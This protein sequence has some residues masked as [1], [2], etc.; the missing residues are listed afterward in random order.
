MAEESAVLNEPDSVYGMLNLI[1]KLE[2]TNGL[3]KEVCQ[4][5]A[6]KFNDYFTHEKNSLAAGLEKLL[7][8]LSELRK[9]VIKEDCHSNFGNYAQLN[10]NVKEECAEALA[11]NLHKLLATLYFW[12]F[13]LEYYNRYYEG[14]GKWYFYKC[15]DNTK[16]M[17][18]WLTDRTSFDNFPFKRG[19]PDETLM[20]T[21]VSTIR[22]KIDTLRKEN[23][24]VALTCTWC[25]M[26]ADPLVWSQLHTLPTL[27]L[28][29]I[30]CQAVMNDKFKDTHRLE[31][32][33]HE[34]LKTISKALSER[35]M[36][37]LKQTDSCVYT[38]FQNKEVHEMEKITLN[39]ER[40]HVYVLF[41][42]GIIERFIEAFTVMQKV[43][44]KWL[45]PSNTIYRESSF[46]FGFV[47]KGANWLM[48]LGWSLIAAQVK[49][50]AVGL[51]GNELKDKDHLTALKNFLKTIEV[52][53][54]ASTHEEDQ[55]SSAE[56]AS[57]GGPSEI[58][59]AQHTDSVPQT[60]EAQATGAVSTADV[61]RVVGDVAKGTGAVVVLGGTAACGL[62][63]TNMFGFAHLVD[64]YL[65]I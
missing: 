61:A 56:P 39:Q 2:Q 35:I 19:F 1:A 20:E 28:V 42:K 25:A 7:K 31:S 38:W 50:Y 54:P 63:Y 24:F 29:W 65:K 8:D 58:E 57:S 10:S 43:C 11:K 48:S 52:K 12:W 26:L 32:G 36:K 16:T 3:K 53:D 45:T 40:F 14:G 55:Q 49:G 46:A 37:L 17:Y 23:A 9:I 4:L 41:L 13:S 6:K 30:F 34:E 64:S 15:T 5:I 27:P 51:V 22:D 59:T 44:Y 60:A 47:V 33:K 21:P 18:Q 62:Y